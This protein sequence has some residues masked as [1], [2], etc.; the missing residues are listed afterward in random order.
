MVETVS[1]FIITIINKN[2]LILFILG[3]LEN[4][5]V[6]VEN[7]KFDYLQDDWGNE[8][9]ISINQAFFLPNNLVQLANNFMLS[10]EERNLVDRFEKDGIFEFN[11]NSRE[12]SSR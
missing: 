8:D 4:F 5:V 3:K 2:L 9:F 11:L 6:G 1:I 10:N 7:Y 12:S